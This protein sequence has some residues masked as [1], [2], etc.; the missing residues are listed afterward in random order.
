[1]PIRTAPW[2][3]GTPCW[4]DLAVPDV[5]AAKEFYTAVLGWTYTDTGEE[6]GHYQIC[7][8]DGHSA[9]GIGPQQSPDQPPA[10]TTYFASDAVDDTAQKIAENGG[11]VLAE[12]FDVPRAGRMCVA[13]DSQGAAFG[14]WQAAESIGAELYNEPGALLWNDA[15]EP[16][17]DA[18]RKFYAAVFG[19]SYQPVEGA[20]AEYTTFHR[21]GDPLGGIGG[22]GDRP[23]GT[24]PHWMTYFSVDDTDAAVT[25]A[26]E[27]GATVLSGPLDTPYGRMAMITDPQGANFSI[28]GTTSP[29]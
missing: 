13:L 4:V 15:A 29:G 8:R 16:D 11:T 12:P 3:T 21:D 22:L 20:G 14:V 7:K 6:L 18:A 9:A 23:P 25:A 26:T 10:W 2:P 5:E 27:R 24:P 28:M 19:Y 17:A 1:M